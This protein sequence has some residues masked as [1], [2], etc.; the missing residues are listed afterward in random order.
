MYQEEKELRRVYTH[1]CN[2][3]PKSKLFAA[4]KPYLDRNTTI[5]THKKNPEVSM[6]SR[7]L[8]TVRGC[9]GVFLLSILTSFFWGL[10]CRTSRLSKFLTHVASS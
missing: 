2:Y 9:I 5:I 4:M 3:L 1:L 10:L 8:V 6:K 7:D